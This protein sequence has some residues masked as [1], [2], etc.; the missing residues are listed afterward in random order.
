MPVPELRVVE[1]IGATFNP[2][3][4]IEDSTE[5]QLDRGEFAE[6]LGL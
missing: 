5:D 3:K 1:A 6:A 2:D 4:P